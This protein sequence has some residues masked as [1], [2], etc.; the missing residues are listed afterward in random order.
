MSI[1]ARELLTGLLVKDPKSRLGGG[2]DDAREIMSHAFFRNINWTDL[3]NKKVGGKMRR[4]TEA[5]WLSW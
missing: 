5:G 4:V 1:E 3:E 2:P